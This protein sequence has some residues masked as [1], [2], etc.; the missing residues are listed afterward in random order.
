MEY[1]MEYGY[2]IFQIPNMGI[3]NNG[4]MEYKTW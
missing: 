4:I 1:K 2:P 3:P